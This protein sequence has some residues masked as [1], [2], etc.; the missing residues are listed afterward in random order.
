MGESAWCG[1]SHGLYSVPILVDISQT[2][3]GFCALFPVCTKMEKELS[4]N[5]LNFL[6]LEN[7]S[8]LETHFRISDRSPWAENWLL[9]VVSE[10][11]GESFLC[12]PPATT[13]MMR[14]SG[15]KRRA[16]RTRPNLS[17]PTFIS[18]VVKTLVGNQTWGEV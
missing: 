14:K 8:E 5:S 6:H 1:S 7:A 4:K 18:P 9:S 15:C 12:V 2:S 16:W 11:Q 10:Y 3:H 13:C 17:L